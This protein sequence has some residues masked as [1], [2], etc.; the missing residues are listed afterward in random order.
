MIAPINTTVHGTLE[1][2]IQQGNFRLQELG[3]ERVR[4][5]K[6]IALVEVEV[7]KV[8]DDIMEDFLDKKTRVIRQGVHDHANKFEDYCYELI[9]LMPWLGPHITKRIN[10]GGMLQMIKCSTPLVAIKGGYFLGKVMDDWMKP[11][12]GG[13]AT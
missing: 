3:T 10:Q 12:T 4:L 7:K 11:Y 13:A 1:E 8:E 9:S 6:K 5:R 2:E